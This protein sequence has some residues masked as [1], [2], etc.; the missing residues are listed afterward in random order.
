MTQPLPS[1]HPLSAREPAGVWLARAVSAVLRTMV[2]T[3]LGLAVIEAGGKMAAIGHG[4][5]HLLFSL[6]NGIV[7]W[8]LAA[9]LMTLD[10]S[11]DDRGRRVYGLAAAV[12]GAC[13]T[14]VA[15]PHVYLPI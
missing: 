6:L 2:Y 15:I 10:R 1:T 4:E 13:A 12:A 7:T 11:E 5:Y 3:A 8:R 9:A 14:H